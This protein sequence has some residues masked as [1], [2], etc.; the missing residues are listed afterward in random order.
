MDAV[1]LDCSVH[2]L[3]KRIGV[4]SGLRD[5]KPRSEFLACFSRAPSSSSSFDPSSPPMSISMGLPSLSSITA[6]RGDF[7]TVRCAKAISPADR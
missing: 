2:D 7:R 4:A 1:D 5:E 3:V 6:Q